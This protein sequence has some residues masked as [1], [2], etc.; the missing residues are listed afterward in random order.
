G[1]GGGRDSRR[2]ISYVCSIVK[3]EQNRN[4]HLY[5]PETSSRWSRR[6]GPPQ[7]RRDRGQVADRSS[8][9]SPHWTP[10]KRERSGHAPAELVVGMD[11]SIGE[12]ALQEPWHRD[13]AGDGDGRVPVHR[14]A[15][16]RIVVDPRTENSRAIRCYETS[17]FRKL[18]ILPQHEMH[19]G[20]PRD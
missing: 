5:W 18:R 3:D 7:P 4:Q 16:A 11:Q 2:I 14:L 1:P 10:R 17:G 6:G 15:A 19:E 8:L 9:S 12:P 13:P 20:H